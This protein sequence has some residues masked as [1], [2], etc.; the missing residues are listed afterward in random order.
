[1]SLEAEIKSNTAAINRLADAVEKL[2]TLGHAPQSEKQQ[3]LDS[4]PGTV[5][6]ESVKNSPPPVVEFEAPTADPSAREALARSQPGAE[7]AAKPPTLEDIKKAL[8]ATAA[9][10]DAVTGTA[11][12]KAILSRFGAVK[13]SQ[14]PVESYA[15][16]IALCESVAA[17]GEV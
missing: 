8:M 17:G 3:W 13:L 7:N 11:K 2:L 1:M 15:E 9:K 5:A 12:S 14:V 4:A 16:F 6:P 10:F